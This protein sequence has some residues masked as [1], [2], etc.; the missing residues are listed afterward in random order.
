MSAPDLSLDH[1]E[2]DS[3]LLDQDG[4]HTQDMPIT[5]K[6]EDQ[7]S[8][9]QNLDDVISATDGCSRSDGESLGDSLKTE[10]KRDSVDEDS[11][12]TDV[13]DLFA[14]ES[15][16]EDEDGDG[17]SHSSRFKSER[18]MVSVNRGKCL[19]VIGALF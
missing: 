13:V 5:N 2:D 11:T 4:S 1:P 17:R 6:R 19:C 15:G 8:D 9:T 12:E 3:L 14:E 7:T 10:V 16:E 18:K